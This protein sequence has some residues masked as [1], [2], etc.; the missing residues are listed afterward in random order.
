MTENE[1]IGTEGASA[2]STTEAKAAEARQAAAAFI[3]S[4][5]EPE[6]APEAAPEAAASPAA[7]AAA[8][9]ASYGTVEAA[10]PRN[11]KKGARIAII[12]AIVIVILAALAGAAFLFTQGTFT[13]TPAAEETQRVPLSDA[14]VIAAFDEVAMDAPDISQYAY[15][16]QDALIGPKFSDIVLNE[17]TNL[18]TAANQIIEC[19]ATATATF[20]NKGI[21]IVVPVTLPFEY[22]PEG[23][24]WVPGEITRGEATA[25]PLASPSATDIIANLNG[26]L[27]TNDPTYGEAMA[28][29][30][31][32]KTTSD[33]T[34]DGGTIG[35]ELSKSIESEADGVVRTELRTSSVTLAVAWSP[36]EGW[37]VT[38][39]DAGQIE[40]TAN[41]VPAPGSEGAAAGSA[42][43]AAAL[44]PTANNQ[45]PENVGNAKYGDSLILS[46][47]LQA[48]SNVGTLSEGNDYT[49]GGA[50]ETADGKVQFVL[51]LNRPL[52]INLN[53]SQYRLTSVAIATNGLEDDVINSLYGKTAT[54]SGSI[55][56]SFATSWSPVGLKTLEIKDV[57]RS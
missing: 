13:E 36:T 35:V 20:K 14:R 30:E 47:T 17:P 32:M 2:P 1:P 49:N 51:V 34:I 24:T 19:T 41:E 33:L 57:P 52:D 42:G 3:Q 55:E 43:T 45:E 31:I 39:S 12:V 50:S 4:A 10:Q 16:S 54:V 37:L 40:T 21:E 5:G 29:A 38:V 23:E 44:D 15:V 27:A 8:L 26:I 48:I 25:T 18:G 56:E 11:V 53:G 22:S 46:G 6:P 9:K 28:D 7:E